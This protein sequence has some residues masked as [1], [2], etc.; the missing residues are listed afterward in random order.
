MDRLSANQY[1]MTIDFIDYIVHPYFQV[2]ALIFPSLD[3]FLEILPQ[4]R[5][6]AVEQLLKSRE[7]RTT[8]LR[9][10]ILSD[11][12]F[13]SQPS[14]QSARISRRMSM[15][16]GTIDLP[17]KI[18]ISSPRSPGQIFGTTRQRGTNDKSKTPSS[19]DLAK[20]F[21]SLSRTQSSSAALDLIQESEAD[22]I[23]GG[24]NSSRSPRLTTRRN[25]HQPI[26]QIP[27]VSDGEQDC[28]K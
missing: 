15:A 17:E 1:Q 7:R 22:I 3:C 27:T 19:N 13:G 10:P 26:L 16:A 24:I 28:K 12:G 14:P 2:L 23:L 9:A 11:P 21:L 6:K 20:S 8:G 18:A 5:A 4:N 25:L